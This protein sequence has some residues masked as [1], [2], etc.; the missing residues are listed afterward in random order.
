MNSDLW[1]VRLQ[2]E[3]FCD[4][5]IQLLKGT[6]K[7]ITIET[8]F[9]YTP[10]GMDSKFVPTMCKAILENYYINGK[11][12]WFYTNSLGA[13]AKAYF[14][15][16][17]FEELKLSLY[18]VIDTISHPEY[19]EYRE[20][21][22]PQEIL[23]SVSLEDVDQNFLKIGDFGAKR[24]GSSMVILTFKRGTDIVDHFIP[25]GVERIHLFKDWFEKV[26]LKK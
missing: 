8:G 26:M 22:N 16:E 2:K 5:H 11:N 6:N 14:T 23:A 3:G 13:G 17:C 1:I 24:E 15:G 21:F 4:G 18:E 19:Q 20:K 10:W 9:N 7:S 25:I 12:H